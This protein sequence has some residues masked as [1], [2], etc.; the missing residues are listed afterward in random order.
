M[1]S[2][3]LQHVLVLTDDLDTTKAFYCDVLGLAV[4]ERP[5]LPFPARRRRRT[6]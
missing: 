2:P 4:G 1:V 6:A 5:P 3:R